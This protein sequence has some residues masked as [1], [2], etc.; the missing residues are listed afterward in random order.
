MSC[1]VNTMCVTSLSFNTMDLAASLVL[2]E[3][4][5]SHK[6]RMHCPSREW[7]IF[8]NGGVAEV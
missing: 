5:L 8:H 6:I 1:I 3:V 4:A 7:R 2:A